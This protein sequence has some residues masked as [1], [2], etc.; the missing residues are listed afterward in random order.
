MTAG[1]APH[2]TSYHPTAQSLEN[3]QL[4]GM[5]LGKVTHTRQ[6]DLWVRVNIPQLWADQDSNWARPIGFNSIGSSNPPVQAWT[7]DPEPPLKWGGFTS[8]WQYP[9][10]PAG[11]SPKEIGP[12]APVGSL[13]VVL[14]L[15]G[16]RNRPG[17]LLTSQHV[18]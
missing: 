5:Y 7:E 18:G 8:N 17:Y 4:F 15:G 9:G 6:Q 2:G 14:F 1:K 10:Q 13:V 16:D 12:G 11:W 3:E